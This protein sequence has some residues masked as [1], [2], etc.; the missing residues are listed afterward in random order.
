MALTS[1]SSNHCLLALCLVYQQISSS[2][3]SPERSSHSSPE[4]QLCDAASIFL[5]LAILHPV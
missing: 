3:S 2:V 4:R 1:T 5:L